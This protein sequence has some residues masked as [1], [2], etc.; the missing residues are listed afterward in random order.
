[1]EMQP[2]IDNFRGG[3]EYLSNFYEGAPVLFDGVYFRNSEAA[4][5]AGKARY[6]LMRMLFAN[7]K[8]GAAKRL[9]KKIPIRADWDAV[10]AD[11]MRRVVHAKFT[12]NPQL[13]WALVDTGDMPLEEGNFWHDNFFGNCYCPKCRGIV[14]QNVLGKILM[15]ERD[16]LRV[17][18]ATQA[19]E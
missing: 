8:P 13:A 1:M 4:Y 10:K 17:G 3:Y 16:R 5:Q 11:Y 19:N 15:E 18:G 2:K 14:G 9:G 6:P 12:Q 7:L